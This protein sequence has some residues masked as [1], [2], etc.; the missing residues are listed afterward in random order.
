M[1]QIT[2]VTSSL[3]LE[4]RGQPRAKVGGVGLEDARVSNAELLSHPSLKKLM[5]EDHEVRRS[6]RLAK[7][8]R[9]VDQ[10][11]QPVAAMRSIVCCGIG[12]GLEHCFEGLVVGRLTS[13]QSPDCHLKWI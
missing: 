9:A 13:T 3:S 1:E 10:V 7:R 5:M 8:A 6:P 2:Q 11:G 4:G 12:L